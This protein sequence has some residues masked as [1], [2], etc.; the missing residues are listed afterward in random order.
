VATRAEEVLEVVR[1][2]RQSGI[3]MDV[4]HLDTNWFAVDWR[5]DLEFA[6]D[7]FP[8]PEN[9][10]RT[11]AAEG[12]HLLEAPPGVEVRRCGGP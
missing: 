9:F 6:P 4:I 5:C 7:R 2:M 8:D 1:K 3:P 11:L 10:C 12:V